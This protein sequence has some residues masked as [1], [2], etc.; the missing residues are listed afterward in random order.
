[1]KTPCK[2]LDGDRVILPRTEGEPKIE[3]EFY[4]TQGRAIQ[5]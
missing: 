1:M 4:E 2:L 3:V 5:W